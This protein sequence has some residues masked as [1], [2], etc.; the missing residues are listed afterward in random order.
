MSAGD[1]VYCDAYGTDVS[2]LEC[3]DCKVKERQMVSSFEECPY[4][5]EIGVLLTSKYNGPGGI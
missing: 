2:I 1:W 5:G 3:K 4:F